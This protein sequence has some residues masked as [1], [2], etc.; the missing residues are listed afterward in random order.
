M[1][2][3]P[4]RWWRMC[5]DLRVL[6]IEEHYGW[7]GARIVRF[8]PFVDRKHLNDIANSHFERLRDVER[9]D[10]LRCRYE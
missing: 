1:N 3:G 10:G 2:L 8:V 6:R 9:R 5:P 7:R 4:L